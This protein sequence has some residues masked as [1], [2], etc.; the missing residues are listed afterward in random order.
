V[1]LDRSYEILSWRPIIEL[2]PRRLAVLMQGDA[3]RLRHR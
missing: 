2:D 3:R 1:S